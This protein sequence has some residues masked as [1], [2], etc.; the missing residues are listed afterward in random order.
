MIKKIAIYIVTAFFIYNGGLDAQQK[1]VQTY[2]NVTSQSTEQSNNDITSYF[3]IVANHITSDSSGYTLNMSLIALRD[4]SK[5][6][7]DTDFKNKWN[8]FLRHSQISG[9]VSLDKSQSINNINLKY[10][11][12]IWDKRDT[13]LY[14]LSE[15]NRIVGDSNSSSKNLEH[16]QGTISKWTQLKYADTLKKQ[17]GLTDDAALAAVGDSMRRW[18]KKDGTSLDSSKINKTFLKL[19]NICSQQLYNTDYFKL[20]RKIRDADNLAEKMVQQKG[21]FTAYPSTTYSYADKKMN[22]YSLGFTY[23]VGIFRNPQKK[24][25]QFQV[26]GSVESKDTTSTKSVN[27]FST[28]VNGSIGINK[29]LAENG[30]KQSI[31]EFNLSGQL[32]HYL[33]NSVKQT[34]PTIDATFKI[35]A[36][37]NTW[38]PLTLS[39]NPGKGNVFGYINVTINIDKG[40]SSSKT[41]TKSSK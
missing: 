15:F 41:A 38:V 3:R 6:R 31:M 13:A 14:W 40:S 9:G 4:S 36:I 35:Q 27:T 21:I 30:Q 12:A 26:A 19:L 20:Q 8:T 22:D 2:D 11:I 24:P 7:R 39:Y 32:K 17:K 23:L 16:I 25:W 18:N 37:K 29:V 1:L 5:W 10:T 34:T 28:S 33:M